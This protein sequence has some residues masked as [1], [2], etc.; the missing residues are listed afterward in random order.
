[1]L[2][3]NHSHY[4]LLHNIVLETVHTIYFFNKGSDTPT[5]QTVDSPTVNPQAPSHPMT[6]GSHT[7]PQLHHRSQEMQEDSRLL[8]CHTVLHDSRNSSLQDQLDPNSSLH[9]NGHN[10]LHDRNSSMLESHSTLHDG[11]SS[12][13]DPQHDLR[14][15]SS[16]DHDSP[17]GRGDPLI[18]LG[19]P[20]T[21]QLT[22]VGHIG[23]NIT[24][25][26]STEG[27]S[28]KTEV[29]TMIYCRMLKNIICKFYMVEI[30]YEAF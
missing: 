15:S 12:M 13:H 6:S 24:P 10:V 14:H 29:W 11:H 28:I 18:P 1:M 30:Y 20:L 21:P 2:I 5:S 4:R 16:M 19:G 9:D 23:G 27:E 17:M 25:I 3:I 26:V 8:D 7:P 22:P